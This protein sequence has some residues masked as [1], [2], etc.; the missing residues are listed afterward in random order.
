[1]AVKLKRFWSFEL[2]GVDNMALRLESLKTLHYIVLYSSNN[3][4]RKNINLL[5]FDSVA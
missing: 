3:N 5:E 2:T 4:V 1:M